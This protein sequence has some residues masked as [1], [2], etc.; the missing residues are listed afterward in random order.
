[1]LF[2][3]AIVI[4]CY[5]GFGL[6][7]TKLHHCITKCIAKCIE[8]LIITCKSHLSIII[9]FIIIIMKDH[10]DFYHLYLIASLILD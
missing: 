1:M 3:A 10:N 4:L 7:A 8:K 6:G 5:V 9:T 2:Y